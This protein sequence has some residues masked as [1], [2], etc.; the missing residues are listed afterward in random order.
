MLTCTPRAPLLCLGPGAAT[1][2]RQAAAVEALGGTARMAPDLPDM[3]VLSSM[4][5]LSAVLWWG[6]ADTARR[7]D[8]ALAA[9]KGPLVPLVTG[10]PDP[11]HALH[12]RHLCVDTTAAGGNAAL[13]GGMA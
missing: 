9:R 11:G 7:I 5:D 12:E 6:E 13:L 8:R 10:L 2:A 1:A 4:P 3:A